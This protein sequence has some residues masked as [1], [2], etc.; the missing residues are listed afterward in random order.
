MHGFRESVR[1][2]RYRMSI[3]RQLAKQQWTA[4]YW[5]EQDGGR[6][7][8]CRQC[9][10]LDRAKG[11]CSVPYG[12]PV[13]KCVVAA[14]ECHLHRVKGMNTLELGSGKRSLAKR[15]IELSGGTWTGLEPN[16]D[17][18]SAV[19]IG[20]QGFGHAA[21]IAF[22]DETFDLV[23]GIQSLEHWEEPH[24]NIPVRSTYA[25]CLREVW[26]VLK[27]G[28]TVYLDAPIHLHGHEMFVT[29]DLPQ[30]R[31]LFDD[32][33]WSGV[34]MER[35]RYDHEPLASYPAPAGDVAGWPSHVAARQPFG[36]VWLLAVTAWRRSSDSV[37]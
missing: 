13:R 12:S 17:A 36:S 4:P 7:V 26:R 24:P 21:D 19:A 31:R 15:V 2:L 6:I 18:G 14:L 33:L 16:L 5:Y 10:K 20:R 9:P 30:I 22:A 32:R 25:A 8:A 34:T 35:W 29:G 37:G 3:A 11:V 27:P 23:F 1:K 28:G